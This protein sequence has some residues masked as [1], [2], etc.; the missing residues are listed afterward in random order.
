MININTGQCDLFIIQRGN[1]TVLNF[2]VIS[3]K[4][5]F[6]KGIIVIKHR[7]LPK[8]EQQQ[9]ILIITIIIIIFNSSIVTNN[10]QILPLGPHANPSRTLHYLCRVINSHH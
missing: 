8:K 5:K 9:Q 4:S 2:G 10:K 7:F 6:D 3:D 1:L